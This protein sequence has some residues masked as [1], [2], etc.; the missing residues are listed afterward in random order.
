MSV[1]TVGPGGGLWPQTPSI[2]VRSEQPIH[3]L[4][5]P[6][7]S[8]TLTRLAVTHN[9]PHGATGPGRTHTSPTSQRARLALATRAELS[10][11]LTSQAN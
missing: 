11:R 8:D 1:L 4:T 7:H 2:C 5:Q 10:C 6:L 9:T 3:L